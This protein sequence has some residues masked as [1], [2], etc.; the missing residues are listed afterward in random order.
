MRSQGGPPR[1]IRWTALS[2]YIVIPHKRSGLNYCSVVG[3]KIN[4]R[5]MRQT[6]T[7]YAASRDDQGAG[8]LLQSAAEQDW[9]PSRRTLR[10]LIADDN[11][12][13]VLTLMALL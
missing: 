1:G 5:Q 7:E 3:K 12:D 2:A 9:R 11:R 4:S 8:I 13:E 6:R 10:I